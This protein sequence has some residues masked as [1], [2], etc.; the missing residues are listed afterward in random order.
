MNVYIKTKV[1]L[2]FGSFEIVCVE[3]R[4]KKQ[5]VTKLIHVKFR[6]TVVHALTHVKALYF[7]VRT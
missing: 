6:C 4:P 1:L 5:I 2:K 7:A 3:M